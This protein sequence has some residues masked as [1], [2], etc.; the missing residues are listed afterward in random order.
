MST[1]HVQNTDPPNVDLIV[2]LKKKKFILLNASCANIFKDIVKLVLEYCWYQ[3]CA[4]SR[5]IPV[6][7]IFEPQK[8]CD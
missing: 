3:F 6:D 1:P 2:K 8:I 7:L 5:N 4:I